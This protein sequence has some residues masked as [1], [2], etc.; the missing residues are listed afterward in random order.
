MEL[1][2]ASDDATSQLSRSAGAFD[3]HCSPDAGER[4]TDTGSLLRVMTFNILAP[5]LVDMSYYA[6]EQGV[7]PA[8]LALRF[9][10]PRIVG[11][12]K[13]FGPDIVFLQE[14]QDLVWHKLHSALSRSFHVMPLESHGPGYQANGNCVLIRRGLAR[15]SSILSSSFQ[16]SP[17]GN[18][19]AQVRFE[20]ADTGVQLY[21]WNTHLEADDD[22]ED[23]ELYSSQEIR[24]IQSKTLVDR[25]ARVSSSAEGANCVHL[26]AGNFNASAQAPEFA[27][28]FGNCRTASLRVVLATQDEGLGE[29]AAAMAVRP[30]DPAPCMRQRLHDPA[31]CME[32]PLEVRWSTDYDGPDDGPSN[33]IVA[34]VAD[35]P[36][37]R[38]DVAVQKVHW[39]PGP[40]VS[41]TVGQHISFALERY[42]SDHLPVGA[43]L[44]LSRHGGA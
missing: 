44:F 32:Q 27:H 8:S 41:G 13:E 31:R 28:I 40:E 7:P 24:N 11:A 18:T 26:W 21:C 36:D 42:G 34:A 35:S 15:P 2:V 16:V 19:A 25:M 29:G 3:V 37:V 14:V 33:L 39:F 22:D 4:V 10:L 9:R 1:A 43:T 20:L 6:D 38:V 5:M 30:Q 17:N 23:E 12:I